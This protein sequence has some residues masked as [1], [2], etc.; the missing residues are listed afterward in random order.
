MFAS[1]TFSPLKPLRPQLSLASRRPG[2]VSLPTDL[3]GEQGVSL[4]EVLVTLTFVGLLS[5]LPLVNLNRQGL[6]LADA[7]DDL[8]SNIRLA[9][10][11]AVSR[12]VHYL[13]TLNSN[14]YSIQRLQDPDGDDVWEPDG[15][16]AEQ[17][18][19]L[20]IGITISEGA[21]ARI[22]FTTRGLLAPLP[23]GTP[24]D[25]VTIRLSTSGESQSEAIDVWPSGQVQ[26]V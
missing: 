10:A 19:E 9:R 17:E 26:R 25:V 6:K 13:V 3:A 11:N 22:E 4:M 21:G 8:T 20:P 15:A 18:F 1:F 12:G 16:F 2:R 7:L 5:A 14:S 24:A 23:D